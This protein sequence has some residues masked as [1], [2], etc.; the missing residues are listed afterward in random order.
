M[1][2]ENITESTSPSSLVIQI[3]DN[4]IK[5]NFLNIIDPTINIQKRI[6]EL[7]DENDELH[8]VKNRIKSIIVKEEIILNYLIWNTLSPELAHK[9]KFDK[10]KF[11]ILGYDIDVIKDNTTWKELYKLGTLKNGFE[12]ITKRHDEL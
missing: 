11:Q 5:I 2:V 4:D 6:K 7:L 3:M 1:K 9:H 8:G 10:N 12:I